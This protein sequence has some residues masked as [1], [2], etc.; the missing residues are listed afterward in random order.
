MILVLDANAVV[1]NPE[2]QGS[3][4]RDIT[5]AIR[6]GALTVI[7]PRIVAAEITARVQKNRRDQRP[8]SDVH[9]APQS[10]QD[11]MQ[12]A[13]DEV[14]RWA[15]Q[16]D[17]PIYLDAEGIVI[18]DT[19]TVA[20]DEVALR[21]INRGRPFN[22]NGGGYRDALHWYTV[23][24]I[25]LEHPDEEIV[26]VSKDVAY[27]IS[28]RDD[29]H[30]TLREEAEAVLTTGTI[31]LCTEFREFVPP[32]K[33]ATDED[34]AFPDE[35]HLSGLV[36]ALFPGGKLHAPELW[37][38]L[39]LEDPIDADVSEPG[40]PELVWAFERELVG[41][42]RSYRTRIRLTA[43]V[44]FDWI[45]W[46]DVED[47]SSRQ[48]LDITAWYVVDDDGFHVDVDRTQLSPAPVFTPTKP[49]HLETTFTTDAAWTRT[50]GLFDGWRSRELVSAINTDILDSNAALIA[51]LQMPPS[52]AEMVGRLAKRG[53]TPNTAMTSLAA[54]IAQR[55]LRNPVVNLAADLA[56]RGA[57]PTRPVADTVARLARRGVTVPYGAV[58]AAAAAAAASSAPID[59]SSDAD[60]TGGVDVADD[61]GVSGEVETPSEID[62]PGNQAL[63]DGRDTHA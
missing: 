53:I 20:H 38:A 14:E 25:A 19:P 40:D 54:D 34:R 18:R 36:T 16:Y 41:G 48:E 3:T 13:V 12:E 10:V 28:S 62:D 50:A 45:D 17:A 8:K 39:D 32:Q 59:D 29:L 55:Q 51:K 26:F 61:A 5:T 11:A 42:G 57:L 35:E 63:E 9:R 47:D 58:A 15:A 56:A 46:P 24:D 30:P 22:E 49:F 43:R 23:L 27:R 2:L 21:A 60:D 44:A 37:V 52:I 31:R 4:W 7:V 33:Y 6:D 1:P